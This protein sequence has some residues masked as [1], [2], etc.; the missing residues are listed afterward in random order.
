MQFYPVGTK[1][2]SRSRGIESPK[3]R[4]LH[5]NAFQQV[6]QDYNIEYEKNV[7]LCVN[8]TET[9]QTKVINNFTYRTYKKNSKMEE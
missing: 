8:D 2:Y 4:E 5:Y 3:Q 1:I 9:K 7:D 6:I